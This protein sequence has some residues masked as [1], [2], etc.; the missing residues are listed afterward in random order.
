V[1]DGH[2]PATRR[3]PGAGDA[4]PRWR[5]A[6]R[7]GCAR[8]TELGRPDPLPA[9]DRH[10]RPARHRAAPGPLALRPAGPA[11]GGVALRAPRRRGARRPR[12]AAGR[13]FAATGPAGRAAAGGVGADAGALLPGEGAVVPVLRPDELQHGFLGGAGIAIVHL[14]GDAVAGTGVRRPAA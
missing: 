7:P 3:V 13:T 12:P 4:E 2:R 6:A 14:P 5:S 10:L 8:P 9:G 11:L 1:R